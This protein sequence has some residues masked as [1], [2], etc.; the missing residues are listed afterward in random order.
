MNEGIER[1][2]RGVAPER[3]FTKKPW[4]EVLIAVVLPAGVV[5]A[6]YLT[7][8]VTDPSTMPF[9]VDT[10]TYIW[11]TNVVHDLGIASLTPDVTNAP[12]PLGDRP[13]YPLVLSLL[14][15]ATGFSSL[16][17]MWL[18]PA[19]FS[20]ALGLAAG[21]LASD[22]ALER[23][24][25]SG[26]IAVAVGGSAFVA[27]T[28]VG[29]AANLALDV[30]AM[31]AAVMALEV[32]RGRRGVWAGAVL[33]VAA[34]LLHWMFALLLVAVLGV[35]AVIRSVRLR[36]ERDRSPRIALGRL[37]RMLA[38][39]TVV[40]VIGLLLLAPQRP[41]RLPEVDPARP[42]PAGRVELRLP[43]LALPVTIP[44][45][46]IGSAL[47]VSDRRRRTAGLLLGTWASLA[48][49]SVVA[50]FLLD[51]PLPPYRW[52]GFALGIPIAIVLGAFAAGDLLV[53]RGRRLL[54]SLA[55]AGALAVGVGL[56]GA[57]ASVWWSRE[58]TLAADEFGQLRTLSSY[59]GSLS[60]QTRIVILIE[61]Y[62]ERAPFNRAWTGL[63]ADRLRFTT[64]I[65]ARIDE[66]APDLGLPPAARERPGTVVVSLDAYREPPGVGRSLGPGVHLIS[67]PDPD[68]VQVGAPPRAPPPVHLAASV[69]V[70]LGL[71]AFSGGGW[72]SLTDLPGIGVASVAPA[73]G[74]AILTS[75]G[76]LAS[77]AG[78]PLHPPWGTV[79]VAAVGIA[80]WLAAFARRGRAPA[81]EDGSG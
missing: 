7:P 54:A 62:R 74:V 4:F 60:P 14:R 1:E 29:Y 28:A 52:A 75:V 18:T 22:G 26:A 51:L 25:R 61:P 78:V 6:I 49:I 46:A 13:G 20:A 59:V 63:P 79:L 64:M 16:S 3:S 9:G 67:G 31:A 17:L 57:G 35:T 56:A 27:W 10:S 47:L 12:K 32:A 24:V 19:L 5:A 45:A 73:F 58:P 11:R 42:G 55:V 39:G 50:W 40:G 72:A 71:L 80:G 76:L 41:A 65:P 36:D 44:L 66:R 15:S 38:I 48:V 21:S 34:V 43:A 2:G 69:V 23:R 70:L 8:F 37:A 33:V 30:V 81:G 53:P 68:G 77:R